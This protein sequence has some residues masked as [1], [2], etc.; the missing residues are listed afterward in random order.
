[1]DEHDG[2]NDVV[3]PALLRSARGIYGKAIRRRLAEAGFDD[4]PRNGPFILGGMANRGLTYAETVEALDISKQA[5]SQLADVMVIRGYLLREADPDDRRRL[6]LTP[7]EW[8]R[9]AGEEVREA[10]EEVDEQLARMITPDQMEGL[11]A[12]L[13]ALAHLNEQTPR[14]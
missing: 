6:V 11:R 8:G 2:H 14:N 5:A 10:V 7:T 4:L 13:R 9:A 3:I 1:M 12:G